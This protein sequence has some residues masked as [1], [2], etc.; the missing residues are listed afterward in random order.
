LKPPGAAGWFESSVVVGVSKT[1]LTEPKR[2][3]DP[4][5][6]TLA[7]TEGLKA[8]MLRV[9]ESSALMEVGTRSSASKWWLS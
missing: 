9:P 2:C 7:P 5:R 8:L 3:A 1:L 6:G 4:P